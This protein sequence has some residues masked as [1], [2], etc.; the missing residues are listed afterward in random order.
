MTTTALGASLILS[1]ASLGSCLVGIFWAERFD[2]DRIKSSVLTRRWLVWVAIAGTILGAVAGGEGPLI[3]LFATLAA[4][5]ALELRSLL[6]LSTAGSIVAASAAPT[7]LVA[8]SEAPDSASFALATTFVVAA[9]ATVAVGEAVAGGRF[10]AVDSVLGAIGPLAIAAALA[11][12]PRLVAQ[13]EAG[14]AL[15][16]ATLFAVTLGDV[17]AYVAGRSLGGPR[18]APRISPAKR[19]SGVIG[20][21]AGALIAFAAFDLL[22]AEGVGGR[23]PLLALVIAFAAVAGDLLES[24]VKRRAG[25]KDAGGWLPGFGGLLDRIDSSVLALPAAY[26]TASALGWE[27]IR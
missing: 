27:V 24:L 5:A 20:N 21:L 16:I 12:A 26:V 17:G 25:V 6:R 14:E 3:A 11:S 15:F 10:R 22:L 13:F 8:V 7:F 1:G 23:W 19:W 2:F 4:V 9:S 18:L